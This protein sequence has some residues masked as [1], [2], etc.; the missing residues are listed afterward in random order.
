MSKMQIIRVLV[1]D[2]EEPFRTTTCANLERRGF[3]ATSAGSGPEA[4]KRVGETNVDVVVLD[5]RMPGMDGNEV[6]RELKTLKPEIPVIML[7]GHGYALSEHEDYG[8]QI[9]YLNKPCA[10]DTLTGMIRYAYHE[11]ETFSG[12]KMP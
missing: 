5:V 7:T 4:M 9:Y 12:R 6:L 10:I 3:C 8:D 11:K 2:D 1:V